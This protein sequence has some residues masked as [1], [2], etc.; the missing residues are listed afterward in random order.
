MYVHYNYNIVV[1]K[2]YGVECK[3]K[4]ICLNYMTKLLLDVWRN[5]FR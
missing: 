1:I 4:N 3:V 5:H 2:T